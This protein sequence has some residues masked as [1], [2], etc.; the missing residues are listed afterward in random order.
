MLF[1]YSD[2]EREGDMVQNLSSQRAGAAPLSS[3]HL[4]QQTYIE[5]VPGTVLVAEREEGA[6]LTNAPYPMGLLI[7]W[8]ES[9]NKA[10]ESVNNKECVNGSK[11]Y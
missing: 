9:D 11:C 1:T 7:E 6:K 8:N 4:I 10:G 5:H 3:L 2:A